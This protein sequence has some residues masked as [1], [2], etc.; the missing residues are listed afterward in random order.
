MP[1]SG[2]KDLGIC[3]TFSMQKTPTPGEVRRHLEAAAST[4]AR[5]RK[6]R[7]RHRGHRKPNRVRDIEAALDALA[8]SAKQIRR[9]SGMAFAHGLPSRDLREASAGIDVERRKLRKML[10]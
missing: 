6:V 9:L 5:A 3:Y 2:R 4:T 7:E 10:R 8:A 1:V